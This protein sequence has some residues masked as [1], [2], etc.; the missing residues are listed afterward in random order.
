[1]ANGNGMM[2]AENVEMREIDGKTAI[3]FDRSFT[4]G[5]LSTSGKTMIIASTGKG[6]TMGD[7]TVAM[8]V[9]RKNRTAAAA[10]A[11]KV[12]K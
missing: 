8:N 1:M 12:A 3:L 2:I 11:K 10:V 4:G 9:Y 5:H 6:F 7:L